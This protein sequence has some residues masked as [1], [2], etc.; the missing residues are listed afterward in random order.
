MD[1]AV[2]RV[3][4]I[5][6]HVAFEREVGIPVFGNEREARGGKGQMEV[7]VQEIGDEEV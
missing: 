6:R 5:G 4:E 3:G 1:S 7:G 2:G